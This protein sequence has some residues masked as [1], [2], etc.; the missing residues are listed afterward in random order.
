[1]LSAGS[2]CTMMLPA[3]LGGAAPT[4]QQLRQLKTVKDASDTLTTERSD[5][6]ELTADE[7]KWCEVCSSKC[8]GH[9]HIHHQVPLYPLRSA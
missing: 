8:F 3:P 7:E 5:G 9:Q 4:T 1:M 6:S 2:P